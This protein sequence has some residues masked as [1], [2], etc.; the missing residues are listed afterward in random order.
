MVDLP[1]G[2]TDASAVEGDHI[3]LALREQKHLDRQ[4]DTA[5]SSAVVDMVA[6]TVYRDPDW[7]I[8]GFDR[9]AGSSDDY[10]V[11]WKRKQVRVETADD[12]NDLTHNHDRTEAAAVVSIDGQTFV[13]WIERVH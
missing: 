8:L 9:V 10:E 3:R 12:D 13:S 5:G 11:R 6:R 7:G 2:I 4:V 1:A